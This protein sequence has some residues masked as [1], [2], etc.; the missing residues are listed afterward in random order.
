M[1]PIVRPFA[2][3][4]LSLS[5]ATFGVGCVTAEETLDDELELDE[6]ELEDELDEGEVEL[7]EASDVNV[8]EVVDNATELPRQAHMK[9]RAGDLTSH[10]WLIDPND[11]IRGKRLAGEAP[12][13]AEEIELEPSDKYLDGAAIDAGHVPSELLEEVLIDE[14]VPTPYSATDIDRIQQLGCHVHGGLWT[15]AGCIFPP[16]A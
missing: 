11:R 2:A 1:S 10:P 3:L 16:A 15:S 13:V 6:A 12:S 9:T 8:D 14:S 4:L 7:D 5:L